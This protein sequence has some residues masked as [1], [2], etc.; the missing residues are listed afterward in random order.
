MRYLTIVIICFLFGCQSRGIDLFLA[1]GDPQYHTTPPSRY[2]FKNIR[3]HRYFSQELE[4]SRAEIFQPRALIQEVDP[5]HFLPSIADHWLEDEAYLLLLPY[6]PVPLSGEARIELQTKNGLDT[7]TLDDMNPNT[8]LAAYLSLMRNVE[9]G[10]TF[11]LLEGGNRS[12]FWKG[13]D[14]TALEMVYQDFLRLTEKN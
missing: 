9:E 13:I 5:S 7:L 14:A 2:Y 11:Y 6:P 10:S 12:P 3:S 1:T 4:G 8:H